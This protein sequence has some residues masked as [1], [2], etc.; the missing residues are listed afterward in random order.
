VTCQRVLRAIIE[1]ERDPWREAGR[2][3]HEQAPPHSG[4]QTERVDTRHARNA[5]GIESLMRPDYGDGVVGITTEFAAGTDGQARNL[6]L[7]RHAKGAMGVTSPRMT[8][9]V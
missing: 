9:A 2:F 1:G 4:F 7:C 3:A 8:G 5:E 6:A